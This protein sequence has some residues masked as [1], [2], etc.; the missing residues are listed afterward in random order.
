MTRGHLAR[1]LT[2]EVDYIK[3]EAS[4]GDRHFK[5]VVNGLIHGARR[6]LGVTLGVT[7]RV[8]L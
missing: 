3:G 1:K 8:A 5:A 4:L 7:L 2:L 6:K